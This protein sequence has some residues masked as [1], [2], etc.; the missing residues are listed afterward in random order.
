M[1][2]PRKNTSEKLAALPGVL[3]YYATWYP[4]LLLKG[5][6]NPSLYRDWGPL[7]AHLRFIERSARRLARS[8]FH[9]MALYQAKMERKQGFLFRCVDIVMELFAMSAAVSRARRMRDEG[10]AEAKRA[11]ELA[12]LFCRN[13]RR[14]VRQLFR[15]LWSNEDGLKNRVAAQVMKDDHLWLA[16]GAMGVDF[17]PETFK[18]QFLTKLRSEQEPEKAKLAATGS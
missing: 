6:V 8:S 5:A 10:H 17:G 4:P 18:T 12:D 7:G 15:D 11:A 16:Q 14:K 1:I 2:D 9:G 3:G 13:S